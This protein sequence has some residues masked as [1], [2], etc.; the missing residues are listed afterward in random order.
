MMHACPRRRRTA[1]PFSLAGIVLPVL[2][3]AGCAAR[4]QSASLTGVVEDNAGRP[5]AGAAVV[6]GAGPVR[7]GVMTGQTGT[8]HFDSLPTGGV[9]VHVF[10][11]GMIYD[12]GHRL[13]PLIK[14]A[15]TYDVRLVAQRPDAGPRFG[16]DPVVAMSRTTVH[17]E[18]KVDA[19]PGS[20]VGSELLA[21]DSADGVA[22]LLHRDATGVASA[23]VRR[24][25]V[26]AHGE[27]R[28]IATDDSCQETPTFPA[29]R[30]ST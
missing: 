2:L 26:D 1:A 7:R 28:F 13:Q 4:T 5:V 3:F 8:Y 10:G 29:A 20:P 25:E 27:W 19:G 15:N 16:G 12:P 22:V 23:E 6:V 17:L 11:P 18:V 9:A 24:G 21:I 14:G 30:S